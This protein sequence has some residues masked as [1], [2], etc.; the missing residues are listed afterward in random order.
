MNQDKLREEFTAE[1]KAGHK[2][3]GMRSYIF[4]GQNASLI[5]YWWLNKMKERDEEIVKMIETLKQEEVIDGRTGRGKKSV[6]AV[7][8]NRTLMK[9]INII[10]KK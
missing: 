10:C 4:T 5:A 9:V 7:I 1:Y 2:D 3:G 8:T 6:T